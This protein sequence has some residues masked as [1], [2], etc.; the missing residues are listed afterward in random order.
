MFNKLK[1][2]TKL[3]A[4]FGI[5]LL[6]LG[7]VVG[8]YQYAASYMSG[9]F[10]SLIDVDLAIRQHAG[11]IRSLMLQCRRDEKD[12]LLTHDKKY[13]EKV[14][15]NVAHLI[16]ETIDI[17]KIAQQGGYSEI[18]EQAKEI[19]KEAHIYEDNFIHLVHSYEKKGLDHKS[20]LQGE[21]RTAAHELA[22]SMKTH[23]VDDLDIAMLMMRRYEKDFR[24]TGK[25][26]YKEKW[27]DSINTYHELLAK[28]HCD[29]VAKPAQQKALT[30]YEALAEKIMNG[31]GKSSDMYAALR[32]AAHDIEAAIKSV[33]VPN[34]EVL[35]L[36][37]RK[38]EKDYMLRGDEKYAQKVNKDADALLASLNKAGV[39]T[40]HIQENT[41]LIAAYKKAFNNM[42]EADREISEELSAMHKAVQVMRP[43]IVKIGKEAD[44]IAHTHIESTT[45]N[46]HKLD[47]LAMTIGAAAF[48]I[49]SALA[50]VIT[51]GITRPIN[52]IIT[53]L[54]NGAEQ[55]AGASGEISSTSQS[56]A[57]GATEQAA[58]LE[59]TSS[60]LEEMASMTR[61][62]AENAILANNMMD[63]ANKAVSQANEAMEGLIHAMEGINT[64]SEETSKI[65]KT[66]DEIAFQTNLL[67]LNAA[68]EAARAGE[69]GAGFA[70]VAEEVRNL[71]MRS[72]EAAKETAKLI[73]DTGSKVKEGSGLLDQTSEAF[74]LV[75]ENSSKTVKVVAEIA[76]AS[77]EQSQGI[78]QINTAMGQIDTVTQSNAAN[79]E[80]GAAASE[81]LSAQTESLKEIVSDL[82]ALVEGGGKKQTAAML[83][84]P[85]VGKVDSQKLLDM[86]TT[87]QKKTKDKQAQKPN[88]V[89]PFDE[90]D[91]FTD[92]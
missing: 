89:I 31:E 22:E 64:S 80:E 34:A 92:F 78:Q 62:N 79:A 49:G 73:E 46:T 63:E 74:S 81:E 55:V 15:K 60:S 65:I 41:A 66:I 43:L 40:L 88:E 67:A 42:V 45:A 44:H 83:S 61:Q 33:H 51:G 53:G 69:A 26:K 71:A 76:T 36:N 52:A 39:D 72:A 17:E 29:S 11:E 25:E 50:F 32:D 12:F 8:I 68:V 87:P 30:S 13:E 84:A 85:V 91:S 90:D 18:L 1:L 5:V 48:V 9:N 23:S 70:V 56:L 35:V 27:T 19:E 86:E 57:E 58:S 59:E 24:L 7:G 3:F 16:E 82:V 14:L 47:R 54:N 38:N 4:G 28:S 20:G 37:I 6:L 10:T 2:K 77:Q 75:T 21:F